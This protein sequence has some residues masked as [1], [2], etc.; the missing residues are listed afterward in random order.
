MLM[1]VVYFIKRFQTE[2]CIFWRVAMGESRVK[3][4]LQFS[5][6]LMQLEKKCHYLSLGNLNS[7][8]VSR[9]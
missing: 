9:V 3:L 2:H 8:D 6:V 4:E 7:H 5:V 1:S